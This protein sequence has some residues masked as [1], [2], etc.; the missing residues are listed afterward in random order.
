MKRH[1]QTH[2]VEKTNSCPLCP[3]RF[4]HANNLKSHFKIHHNDLIQF[5]PKNLRILQYFCSI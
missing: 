4:K 2:S 3:S 5:D 1:L